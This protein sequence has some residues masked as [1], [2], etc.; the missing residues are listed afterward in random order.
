[1]EEEKHVKSIFDQFTVKDQNRR[2]ITCIPLKKYI[3]EIFEMKKIIK[4]G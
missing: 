4:W 1:M 3:Q 2:I